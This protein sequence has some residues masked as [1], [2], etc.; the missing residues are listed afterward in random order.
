[1]L[2]GSLT[3]RITYHDVVRFL[4]QRPQVELVLKGVRREKSVPVRTYAKITQDTSVVTRRIIYHYRYLLT[5]SFPCVSHLTLN[6]IRTHLMLWNLHYI[7]IHHPLS[8][9]PQTH[10][11]TKALCGPYWTSYKL[12][13]QCKSIGSCWWHSVRIRLLPKD[14]MSNS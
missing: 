2:H 9:C 7:S 4:L 13:P 6:L 5:S 8:P 1:M 10:A 14:P 3:T 11:T 12:E